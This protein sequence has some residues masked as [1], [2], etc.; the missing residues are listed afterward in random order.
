M[1]SADDLRFIVFGDDWGRHV[2]TMQH[3][4]GRLTDRHE[5]IWVNGIGHREPQF[6]LGDMRRAAGKA[7]ALVQRRHSAPDLPSAP[8]ATSPSQ[9][10]EP[11]VLPWHSRRMVAR[12]N[13]WSLLRDIGRATRRTRAAR[14]VL[15]TG[16]PPSANVV[17]H[18]GED[19]SLYFCMDDFLV[20]PGT[21]PRTMEPLERALLQ[22]VDA[23]VATAAT[24]LEKKR[25]ASG[26]GYLLPQGVNFDHFAAPQP[27]PAELRALP[28]PIIGFAGGVGDA[29]DYET[30]AHIA[31]LNHGGSLVFVGPV[32]SQHPAL[33]LPG[34]HV[35]G[36]RPYADL[37]AYVRAF[38]VG[39]IPYVDN[40]WIR[41][42][43]PLKLLEYLAAEIPVVVSPMP[44]ARKYGEVVTVAPLGEAFARAAIE[45][46]NT[47]LAQRTRGSLVAR[48]NTWEVR[49]ERF[50]EIVAELLDTRR[51]P[52]LHVAYRSAAAG[53]GRPLVSS[54]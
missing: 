27:V 8:I 32:T 16:S 34:V 2:S 26:R 45:A 53:S 49:A 33:R 4:L 30:I 52:T 18:C 25:C 29:I 13:R 10:V 44:E 31:R 12:F 40:D 28:R 36:P 24:L 38:D 22:R 15:V 11:R 7:R 41:A 51:V 46:T 47:T 42:V 54:Q 1:S 6:S 50:L 21:S 9:I 39:I 37:P 14:T 17:G 5:M 19:L 20:I 43:D 23:V 3:L 35:I 48:Q